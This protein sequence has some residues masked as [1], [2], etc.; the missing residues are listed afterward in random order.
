MQLHFS[1]LE[2]QASSDV[3]TQHVTDI[4]H[5][6]VGGKRYSTHFET[7]I[8]SRSSYF[9]RL[10]RIDD[11]S[12]KVLLYLK[13]CSIDST[14]AIFVNRDGDLF[15]YA[16][17]FMRDGKRAALPQNTDILQQLVREA[18]FFGMDIW[19]IE[20]QKRLEEESRRESQIHDL[21]SAID[22]RVAQIS[23]SIYFNGF[24]P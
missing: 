11:V 20:L 15:A 6:N 13:N 21:L 3:T 10:V 1:S 18:E 7:L 12:G 5:L 17:Q 16:L 14:G 24:K 2:F 9:N 19:K 4:V 8:R 22:T 23:E